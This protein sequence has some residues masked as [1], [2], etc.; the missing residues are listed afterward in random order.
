[1][2]GGQKWTLE[3]WKVNTEYAGWNAN[4][5]FSPS[6]IAI[7]DGNG[8]AVLS[9]S[10]W[11][12]LTDADLARIVACINALAGVDDPADYIDR[13]EA[14]RMSL[15]RQRDELAAA[16]RLYQKAG[17]G[18]STDFRVQAEASDDARAALAKVAKP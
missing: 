17:I 4:G 12:T 5:G 8:E 16:L 1:M 7:F 15:I 9:A 3:P 10:E 14:T 6:P 18:N 13:V 2:S 11:M